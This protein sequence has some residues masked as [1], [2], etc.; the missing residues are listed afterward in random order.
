MRKFTLI[1]ASL[2]LSLGTVKAESEYWSYAKT[3]TVGDKITDFSTITDGQTVAFKNVGQNRYI[4]ISLEAEAGVSTSVTG[5]SVFKLHRVAETTNQF[6]IES[7]RE[8]YYFPQIQNNGW[9]NY[10]MTNAGNPTAFEFLST[11]ADGTTLGEGQ[12]VVKS[13]TAEA[14]FDGGANDFTGWQ[15][16]GNNSKYEV[17]IVTPSTETYTTLHFTQNYRKNSK[18]W[19]A[20]D[21]LNETCPQDVLTAR[22]NENHVVRGALTDINVPQD[23]NITITFQHNGGDH[24]MKILGADIINANG[25]V[26]KSD[27]HF[28][29]TGNSN[30]LNEYILS[31][32]NAG[33]YTLRYFVCDGNDNDHNL[34]NAQGNVTVMGAKLRETTLTATLTNAIGNFEF[35]YEG[36]PGTEPQITGVYGYTLSNKSFDKNYFTA[37]ITFPFPVSNPTTTN[38]TMI[39]NFNAT[40]RWHAVGEDVKVQTAA[41]SL[42]A[43]DE[44]MWAIYPSCTNGVFSFTVKNIATGKFVTVN[45]DQN[46]FDT[47]GTVTLTEEGTALEAITWLSAPCF[48]IPNKTLYLTINGTA[49]TDVYLAT[50]TGGNNSHSGNKLHFPALTALTAYTVDISD[51]KAATLTTPIAVSRPTGVTAGYVS[52]VNTD[53]KV[54]TYTDVTTIPAGESVVI[55]GEAGTYTFSATNDAEEFENENYLVGYTVATDIPEGQT[56]YALGNKTNGVAF[57]S[58]TGTQYAAYKAYLQ[59]PEADAQAIGY[60]NVFGGEGTTSIEN[61]EV[62]TQNSVVIFDLMGRRVETMTEGNIYIVNG[63]KIIR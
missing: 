27:Y 37:A 19:D 15:G 49:D 23:G 39:A 5:L 54:L 43:I 33:D 56:V 8:G 16:K 24:A 21:N 44:W 3:V 40:Q 25:D 62:A 12:F 53:T 20:G 18:F 38:A 34:E 57:Y 59:L 14:Y 36:I 47:K 17:Y 22:D 48:K 32:V 6:T 28:G 13:T 52:G 7:A 46:S 29:S 55:F 41:P 58:F 2:F 9:P 61:T 63:K 31:D 4:T 50:W 35:T 51:A 11:M 26:V 10:Y 1:L 30:S 60:F 42:S 45:K